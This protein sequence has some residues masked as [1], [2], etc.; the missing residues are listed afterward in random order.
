M[1]RVNKSAA[2]V[3]DLKWRQSGKVVTLYWG[4]NRNT[5]EDIVWQVL[6]G[7]RHT[8]MRHTGQNIARLT[9]ELVEAIKA[10]DIEWTTRNGDLPD[11]F[12]GKFRPRA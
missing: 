1:V 5:G 3:G 10:G 7:N 11:R 6:D 9:G 2:R 12:I 8:T 4:T